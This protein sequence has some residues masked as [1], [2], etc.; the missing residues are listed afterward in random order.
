M[1]S[2]ITQKD[3]VK[4]TNLSTYTVSRALSGKSG[5]SDETRARVINASKELGYIKPSTKEYL[6][7]ILMVVPESDLNDA[8]F[9]MRVLQG[10]ENAAT[11]KNYALQIKVVK[12]CE[13]SMTL[14]DVE[15]ASGVIYAG[16]KSLV[17]AQKYKG[18][19][20]SLLMTYPPESLFEMD[21][22]HTGDRE[23]GFSVCNM[24]MNWK[25]TAIAFY[26][27]TER[28]STISQ[29]EG[30]Q[31]AL[32]AKNL[33]LSKIWKD[34]KY[35]QPSTMM[36]ELEKLKEINDLP[37]AI[38]CSYEKLAQSLFFILNNLQLAIPNDISITAFNCD[39]STTQSI[40]LTGSGLNK[41]EYG[42]QAFDV[43][44]ERIEK[45]DLPYRRITVLPTLMKQKTAGPAPD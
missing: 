37:S 19:R 14:Q 44:C 18:I 9:W 41:L 7:Y 33:E 20:P 29:L 38:I 34:E 17:Y 39:L 43:L 3:I 12:D 42:K 5:I 2:K 28:P 32:K 8:T 4:A 11:R 26:G 22:I 45:T 15:K 35:L 27:T 21:I 24:L 1:A 10:I 13:D 31:D 23:A 30:V 36:A 25:H 6:P 40:P 16:N